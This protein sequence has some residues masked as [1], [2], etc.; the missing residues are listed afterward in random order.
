MSTNSFPP[1]KKDSDSNH[2]PVST[3]GEHLT[4]TGS[5][6]AKG[7]VRLKGRVHGD[8][9]CAARVL[10]E[11]SQSKGN[12]VADEVVIGG[13]LEGLVRALNATLRSRCHVEGDLFHRTI[14]VEHG[15]HFVGK[16]RHTAE[17]LSNRAEAEGRLAAHLELISRQP[18]PQPES[19]AP[20]RPRMV[21]KRTLSESA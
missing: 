3:I 5:V 10:S 6:T 20:Q 15:A 7:E 9:E 4:I 8:I 13:R 18:Q 19:H 1:A 11:N 14:A 2:L 16:S 21:F 12:V 17:P